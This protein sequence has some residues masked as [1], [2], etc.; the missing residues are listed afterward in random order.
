[1]QSFT[2]VNASAMLR[3]MCM[4]MPCRTMSARKCTCY[5]VKE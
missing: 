5:G 3:V 4:C 2:V 1:M